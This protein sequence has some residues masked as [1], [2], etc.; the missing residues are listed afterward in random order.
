MIRP[1]PARWFELLVARDDATLALEALARTGAVELEA[2][3]SAMLPAG[4][5]D[6]RVPMQQFSE[7]ALRYHAYWPTDRWQASAFPEPPARTLERCLSKIRSWAQ[8]AEPLIGQLQRGEAERGDLLRA[9][10]VLDALA[11]SRIDLAQMA[12]AGPV[13]QARL[14]VFAQGGEPVAPPGLLVRRFEADAQAHALALGTAEEIERLAQQT[15]AQK[16]GAWP[17]PTWLQSDHAR[18]DERVATRLGELERDGVFA[19]TQL[20]ELADRHDLRGVL[21]DIARL[22]WVL[23]NV[24]ALESG[25]LFCWVTG[26]TSDLE[27][28]QLAAVLDRSP[29]RSI[30]HA[31]P[32]PAAT[33]AP[34]LLANP[35]WARPYEI[36]SRAMGMPSHDEA[37]PSVLLAFVVPLMFGYM[38]ADVGQGLLIAIAGFVLRRRF[39]LARLFVAGGLVAALFGTLF[40]SAFSLQAFRPLWFEPLD[41]PLT[42]LLVPLVGGAALLATGLLLSAVEAF[43]RGELAAWLGSDA[44]FIA[45][46]VGL[47]V[48]FVQPAGFAVAA[49]GACVFCLG[50]GLRERRFAAVAGA[51]GELVERTLQIVINTLSF[52]RV[53]AFALA[54]AGLS[55]AIV[56]LMHAS[57]NVIVQALVLIAGNAVV[58]VLEGLVVSIQT[59]RLVLFEFFARFLVAGGRLFR[60]LPVPPS[61]LQERAMK[62]SYKFTTA[63]VALALVMGIGATALLVAGAPALAATAPGTAATGGTG[64]GDASGFGLIAAAVSTALAA[65]GAGIAVARVG[66]AAVGA[67]AEKPELFGRLLIF[68]GLAEGIAIYGLIVSILILN[69]LV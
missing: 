5:T 19:R 2:R 55:S 49:L 53:G 6:I 32:P 60:P 9:K 3:P 8:E 51:L 58:I 63:L 29:A 16:G 24:R 66:T 11:A 22:E 64:G 42:V 47:L 37:D 40:G 48:G 13:L 69:R 36:F 39:P 35:W 33:S 18:N 26:W 34:L 7:L 52:A 30:L 54:H 21:G 25:E 12:S 57:G 20:S 14:F 44:G 10:R 46:Y 1:R 31:P 68:V 23:E 43:W 67:L 65:L 56:A 50:H 59:T 28:R 15:T 17:L 61:T 62:T 4:L 45:V 27:G 41:D 38:F